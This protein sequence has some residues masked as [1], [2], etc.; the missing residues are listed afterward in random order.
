MRPPAEG[1][2]HEAC[3][4]HVSVSAG[5][6]PARRHVCGMQFDPCIHPKSHGPI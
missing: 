2:G 5:G 1:W 4:R 3:R 6:G